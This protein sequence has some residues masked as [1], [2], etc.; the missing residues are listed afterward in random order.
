VVIVLIIVGAGAA[1]AYVL[2]ARRTPAPVLDLSLLEIPTM[3]TAVVGGFIYRS[4]IGAMPFLLPLLLQLGFDLTAFQSGLITL[5]NVVGAMGMKTVIPI[6]LRRYGFRRV[7]V[8]NALISAAL[9]AACATFTPGVSFAWIVGV[10]IVGGFFRSLEFT[11]LNTIAYADVDNRRM[12]RATSLVAVAQ[13]VSI[14][15]GVAIGAL[16]VDLTLWARG[17]DTITAADFQPA[18]LIIAVIAGCASFIFARMPADAGAEL[19]RR[20]TAPAAGATEAT[21]QRMG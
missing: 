5:S 16:A 3:R 10:L 17:R 8:V 11:S 4:G 21:D 2:H 14:S 20:S 1:Y 18:Y 6:I 12:S 19:A 9:V 15:V 7:L 13:Q